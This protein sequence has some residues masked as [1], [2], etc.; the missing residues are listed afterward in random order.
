MTDQITIDA[1]N[2]QWGR[3]FG[4]PLCFKTPSR[5]TLARRPYLIGMLQGRPPICAAE[6]DINLLDRR[7]NPPVPSGTGP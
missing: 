2:I 5:R 7:S 3:P 4:L 6:S 1:V